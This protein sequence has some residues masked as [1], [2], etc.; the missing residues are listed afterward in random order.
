MAGISGLNDF[1]DFEQ[2]ATATPS[3][4]Q[5]EEMALTHAT[6]EALEARKA[7]LEEQL[8]QTVVEIRERRK[9]AATRLSRA[10]A[11]EILKIQASGGTLPEPAELATLIAEASKKEERRAAA[12]ARAAA[13]AKPVAKK[14]GRRK[15][16]TPKASTRGT[17]ASRKPAA[18]APA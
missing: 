15:K 3:C 12:E 16:P 10:Y 9:N 18:A 4:G 13:K 11:R 6:L 2:R 1:N 8:A 5:P 7:R 17:R 14:V